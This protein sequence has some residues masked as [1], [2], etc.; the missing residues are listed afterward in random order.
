MK[1]SMR[2]GLVRSLGILT[3]AVTALWLSQGICEAETY[4][5]SSN[6]DYF[7][8]RCT[9]HPNAISKVFDGVI[10]KGH[11]VGCQ[12]KSY[13]CM[14]YEGKYQCRDNFGVAVIPF[15][16]SMNDLK[17]FCSL[18]CTNPVCASGWE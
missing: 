17:R 10:E 5:C 9:V 16:F 4:M 12:F 14:K 7:S 6:P 18:L 13:S 11:L 1:R 8:K 15:D 3:L 2:R